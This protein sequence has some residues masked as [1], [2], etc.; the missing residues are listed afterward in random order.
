MKKIL[1]I[2]PASF[3]IILSLFF[4]INNKEEDPTNYDYSTNLIDVNLTGAVV[5]PKIYKVS[6]GTRLESLINY[7]G[8]F[9]E[10]ADTSNIN[11]NEIITN[12][13]TISIPFIQNSVEV[14]VNINTAR[15][16]ELLTIPHI[17]EQRAA[18]II[19]YRQTN[20]FFKKIEDIINVKYIGNATFDKIKNYI[21]V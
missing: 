13:K 8:G 12:A 18:S 6:S 11:L 1:L 2:I 14:K 10:E 3:I 4:F 17:T 20:G 21:T 16:E 15:F 19:I 7:A 9:L 5:F